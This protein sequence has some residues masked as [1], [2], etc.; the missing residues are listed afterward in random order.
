LAFKFEY[1][2]LALIFLVIGA[3]NLIALSIFMYDI[4]VGR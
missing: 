1:F 2:N 4:W 3:L